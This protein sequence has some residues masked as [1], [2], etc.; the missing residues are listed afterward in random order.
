[1]FFAIIA[2]TPVKWMIDRNVPSLVAIGLVLLAAVTLV[3]LTSMMIGASISQFNESLP[4]YQQRL[5]DMKDSLIQFLLVKGIDI[6]D[7]GVL[8]AINPGV[9][10][11][12]ANNTFLQITDILKNTLLIMLTVMFILFD[13]VEMPKKTAA[14]PNGAHEKTVNLIIE[15]IQSTNNYMV[16]KAFVSLLTGVQACTPL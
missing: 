4:E 15:I 12:Y 1:M 16:L 3:V 8:H 6:R 14:L 13:A 11:K 9:V 10:L 7:A 5:S 2:I